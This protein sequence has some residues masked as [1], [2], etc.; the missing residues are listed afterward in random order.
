MQTSPAD[1]DLVMLIVQSCAVTAALAVVEAAV[2]AGSS[3]IPL[4]VA[5]LVTVPLIAPEAVNVSEAPGP[6]MIE[7]SMRPS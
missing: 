3:N 7:P 4:A 6:R 1:G 2:E 5:M